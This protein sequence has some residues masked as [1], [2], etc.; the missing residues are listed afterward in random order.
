MCAPCFSHKGRDSWFLVDPVRVSGFK[1]KCSYVVVVA[2]VISTSASRT[3]S[4]VTVS[5]VTVS[6]VLSGVSVK[7]LMGRDVWGGQGGSGRSDAILSPAVMR[8]MESVLLVIGTRIEECKESKLL[9][10][11]LGGPTRECSSKSHV[12]SIEKVTPELTYEDVNGATLMFCAECKKIN[13]E[14]ASEDGMIEWGSV[15]VAVRMRSCCV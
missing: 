12:V 15:D 13:V 5:P 11:V 9:V 8:M 10:R 14:S 7:G 4:T 2:G 6:R 1:V 3:S